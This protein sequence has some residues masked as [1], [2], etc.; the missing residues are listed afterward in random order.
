[1]NA[2]LVA[3]CP[4][5]TVIKN[6]TGRAM[7]GYST[8][9]ATTMSLRCAKGWICFAR[10][11]TG[12]QQYNFQDGLVFLA[13]VIPG[14]PRSL[15]LSV[16]IPRCPWMLYRDA[17]QLPNIDLP[18]RG[19]PF[20]LAQS[21]FPHPLNAVDAKPNSAKSYPRDSFSSCLFLVRDVHRGHL[22]RPPHRSMA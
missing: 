1:L 15:C 11:G 19:M 16:C 18:V 2:R 8:L 3:G 14:I 9:A 22:L 7:W 20:Q 17:V 12:Q 6:P 13:S 4:L 21:P 10:P 5:L